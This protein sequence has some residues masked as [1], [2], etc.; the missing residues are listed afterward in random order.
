MIQNLD[1]TRMSRKWNVKVR[2]N[3]GATTRDMY[4]HL[5]ALLRKEP[6]HLILH[7][8][9]NDASDKN[10]TSDMLYEKITRLKR[11][12]ESKV[13][14]MDVTLSCPPVRSD[15]G[16][17]NVKLVHIRNQ[18]KRNGYKIIENGNITYEHPGKKGLHLNSRGTGR[19]A[20]NMIACIKRL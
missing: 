9:T 16:I 14:G 2:P 1:A 8:G 7:I 15:N 19:L 6:K 4:D 5:N 13:K 17:A 11:Y 12:A 20:M 18:L 3:P 10:V